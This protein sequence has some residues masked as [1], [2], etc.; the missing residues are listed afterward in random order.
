MNPNKD[1][2]SEFLHTPN[3]YDPRTNKQQK[4]D[5]KSNDPHEEFIVSNSD[6]EKAKEIIKN[7]PPTVIPYVSPPESQTIEYWDS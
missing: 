5:D 7:N 2:F 6:I 1:L 3:P 4:D